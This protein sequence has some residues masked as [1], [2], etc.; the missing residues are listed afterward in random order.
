MKNETQFEQTKK[1]YAA[2]QMEIVEL[3]HQAN[4]LSCSD[5]ST[6]SYCGGTL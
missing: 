3:N 2:P 1:E 6:D 4:L 5:G